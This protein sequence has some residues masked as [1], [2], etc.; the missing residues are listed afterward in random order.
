MIEA[1]GLWV[2]IVLSIALVGLGVMLGLIWGRSDPEPTWI[3]GYSEGYLDCLAGS[4]R[5]LVT[6]T[7]YAPDHSR[8]LEEDST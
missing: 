5:S 6:S 8:T 4:R 3:D 2:P 1:S 7:V